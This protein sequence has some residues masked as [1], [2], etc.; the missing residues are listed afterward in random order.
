VAEKDLIIKTA[1]GTAPAS[2]FPPQSHGHN[3]RAGVIVDAF[4]PRAAMDN[5]AERLAD[6][7]YSDGWAVLDSRFFDQAG[8]GRHWSRMAQLFTETLH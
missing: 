4:G 5:I 6:Q 8:Y 7:G 1:D 2:Y 3:D